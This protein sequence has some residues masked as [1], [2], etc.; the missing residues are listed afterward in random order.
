MA[1]HKLCKSI[2]PHATRFLLNFTKLYI[3]IYIYIYIYSKILALHALNRS[4]FYKNPHHFVIAN[5]A[6]RLKADSLG[7]DTSLH[8]V[9]L[10]MTGFLSFLDCHDFATQMQS[11]QANLAMT[12]FFTSLTT[13]KGIQMI[14]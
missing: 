9:S 11:L 3:Y 4:L 5:I 6:N 10:S 1:N 12:T 2:N 13:H 7:L 8:F 14:T